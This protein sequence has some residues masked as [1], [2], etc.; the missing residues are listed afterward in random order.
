MIRFQAADGL[1]TRATFDE[2]G[3]PVQFSMPNGL[4]ISLRWLSDTQLLATALLADGTQV[5]APVQLASNAQP[6]LA[7]RLA[8]QNPASVSLPA[9]A[10]VQIEV[11]RCGNLP[12]VGASVELFV[13]VTSGLGTIIHVERLPAFE[14][15][16]TG[17]YQ[18]TIPL[19][20]SPGADVTELCNDLFEVLQNACEIVGPLVE[21]VCIALSAAAAIL[22]PALLPYIMEWCQANQFYVT[23]ICDGLGAA[24][25]SPL[26]EFIG[27]VVD[28]PPLGLRYVLVP[29]SVRDFRFRK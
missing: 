10:P 21:P 1:V 22:Q 16:T 28:A 27:S 9:A 5:N 7:Q 11:T 29:F 3:R 23:S 24:D 4:T 6:R 25:P 15:G 8:G 19:E 20:G 2:S 13:V 12:L 18:T 17:T 26:C 14:V